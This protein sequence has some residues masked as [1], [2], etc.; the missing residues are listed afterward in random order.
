MRSIESL[1]IIDLANYNIVLLLEMLALDMEPVIIAV[2][3]ASPSLPTGS[4]AGQS[5]ALALLKTMH[6]DP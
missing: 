5:G 4:S 2:P 6:D 3:T 1:N